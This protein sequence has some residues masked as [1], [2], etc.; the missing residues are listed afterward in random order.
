M[1]FNPCAV[2]VTRAL[3]DQVV[4]W[5]NAHTEVSRDL[6]AANLRLAEDAMLIEQL[7]ADHDKLAARLKKM[8]LAQQQPATR[9][10]P[11]PSTPSSSGK[12]GRLSFLGRLTTPRHS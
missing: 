11:T 4:A 3:S 5:Q 2:Q 10:L 6:V 12:G 8:S 7:K 1:V 9:E